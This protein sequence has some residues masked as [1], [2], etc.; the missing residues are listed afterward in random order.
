MT[1]EYFENTFWR[2]SEIFFEREVF[3]LAAPLFFLISLPFFCFDFCF[4]LFIYLPL[5][6]LILDF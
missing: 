5:P 4:D 3:G 6:F 1:S 2:K